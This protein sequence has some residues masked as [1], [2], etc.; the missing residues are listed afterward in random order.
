MRQSNI[1]LNIGSCIDGEKKNN[2]TWAEKKQ[3]LALSC[4]IKAISISTTL[5]LLPIQKQNVVGMN[6]KL[7]HYS[8][9]CIPKLIQLKYWYCLKLVLWNTEIHAISYWTYL[10]QYWNTAYCYYTFTKWCVKKCTS[11]NSIHNVKS[12]STDTS[13]IIY[14]H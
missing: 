7:K 2:N 9:R 4:L 6:L 3:I 12:S 8:G 14:I 5:F 1:R 13:F 10:N 11:K